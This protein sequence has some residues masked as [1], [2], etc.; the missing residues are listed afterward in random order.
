M[1]KILIAEDD[2]E[3]CLL[4]QRVLTKNGYA[5]KGVSNGQEALEVVSDVYCVV[6]GASERRKLRSQGPVG[7]IRAQRRM[8]GDGALVRR[9]DEIAA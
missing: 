3:L 6:D 5:V 9:Y 2:K 7:G 4:F 1:L 8:E